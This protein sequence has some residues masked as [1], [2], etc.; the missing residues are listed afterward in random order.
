MLLKK[1]PRKLN[2][3][4]IPTDCKTWMRFAHIWESPLLNEEKIRLSFR[5]LLGVEPFQERVDIG[6]GMQAF[7]RF[8]RAGE[9]QPQVRQARERLLD[10]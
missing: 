10:C 2:G 7:L 3:V 8:Y 1:L 5:L 4:P 6:R 9:E